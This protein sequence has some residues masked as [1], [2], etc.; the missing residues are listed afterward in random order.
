MLKIT[1]KSE[2]MTNEE[3]AT[4]IDQHRLNE[5]W[6]HLEPKIATQPSLDE[7][8]MAGKLKMMQQ[9]YGEALNFYTSV[10]E[11]DS[12]NSEALAKITAIKSILNISNSFYYENTYLDDGLYE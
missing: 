12:K 6:R 10:L 8:M 2:N 1:K 4:L 9:K 3:I 5:A 11:L 7:F